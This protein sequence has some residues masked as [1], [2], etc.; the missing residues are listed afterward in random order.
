MRRRIVSIEDKQEIK[1][2]FLLSCRG[3]GLY[4]LKINKRFEENSFSLAGRG[5][6]PMTGLPITPNPSCRPL[7]LAVPSN[8]QYP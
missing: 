1:R 5:Q 4:Q 2:K 7:T 3:E 6:S 8:K